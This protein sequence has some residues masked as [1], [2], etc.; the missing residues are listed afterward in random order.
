MNA[1]VV[2]ARDELRLADLADAN[3]AARLEGFVAEHAEGTVFQRPVWLQAVAA[4]TG[5][6]ALALVCE[7]RGELRAFLPLSEVHSPVFGRL[8]ASTGFAV[9]GG[10]LAHDDDA[11]RAVI[12]AAEE[13]AQR[14]SCPTIELRGGAMPEDRAGWHVQAQSHCG[15]AWD[16]AEDDE[17]QPEFFASL[18][19]EEIMPAHLVAAQIDDGLHAALFPARKRCG[20]GLIAA[21]QLAGNDFVRVVVEK[22]HEPMI[23]VVTPCRHE[24]ARSASHETWPS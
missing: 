10:V 19:F 20:R 13:L 4:G 2:I 5:N 22:P 6:P 18:F 12:L 23:A 9:G 1:P 3:E 14:R 8:L 7:R 24:G 16:L 15:F 11:A 21:P 17:A